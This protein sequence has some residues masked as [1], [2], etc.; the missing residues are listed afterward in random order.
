MLYIA[1]GLLGHPAKPSAREEI[2]SSELQLQAMSQ[3]IVSHALS[4]EATT[5]GTSHAGPS[6]S[7]SAH[8]ATA[9][10]SELSQ[11]L[12]T[13]TKDV[14]AVAQAIRESLALLAELVFGA[15]EEAGKGRDAGAVDEQWRLVTTALAE[16]ADDDGATHE[17][18]H[19]GHDCRDP[20]VTAVPADIK[21]LLSRLDSRLGTLSDQMMGKNHAGQASYPQDIVDIKDSIHR[22]EDSLASRPADRAQEARELATKDPMMA[23]HEIAGRLATAQGVKD[24]H[25]QSVVDRELF[26]SKLHDLHPE[27]AGEDHMAAIREIAGQLAT[28]QGVKELHGQSVADRE[29]LVSKVRDLQAEQAE[30]RSARLLSASLGRIGVARLEDLSSHT[31]ANAALLKSES[32][33]RARDFDRLE[34]LVGRNRIGQLEAQH[35]LEERGRADQGA[36]QECV[37]MLRGLTAAPEPPPVVAPSHA[38]DGAAPPAI[39]QRSSELA[40]DRTEQRELI[41]QSAD[42]SG[43]LDRIS[44]MIGRNRVG[45]LEAQHALEERRLADQGALQECLELLRELVSVQARDAVPGVSADCGIAASDRRE[46]AEERAAQLEAIARTVD[47]SISAAVHASGFTAERVAGDSRAIDQLHAELCAERATVDAREEIINSMKASALSSDAQLRA[48]DGIAEDLSQLGERLLGGQARILRLIGEQ[49][50]EVLE[51]VQEVPSTLHLQS[52]RAEALETRG[53]RD[54]ELAGL[55]DSL[56][57]LQ[58]QMHVQ[59]ALQRI[60][61]QLARLQLS[62]S[63]M[64][65]APMERPHDTRDAG[66]EAQRLQ[67]CMEGLQG[68]MLQSLASA[69]TTQAQQLQALESAQTSQLQAV[70]AEM[71]AHESRSFASAVE[72]GEELAQSRAQAQVEAQRCEIAE[73]RLQNVEMQSQRAGNGESATLWLPADRDNGTPRSIERHDPTIAFRR[74]LERLG[75]E[76]ARKDDVIAELHEELQV[77]RSRR[78]RISPRDPHGEMFESRMPS[79]PPSSANLRPGGPPVPPLALHGSSFSGG[80]KKRM[81][82][83]G[84]PSP[85]VSFL[86]PLNAKLLQRASL[87]GRTAPVSML[88]L[89]PADTPRVD[90]RLQSQPL[91]GDF[92]DMESTSDTTRSAGYTGSFG[93]AGVADGVSVAGSVTDDCT[94]GVGV[95]GASRSGIS[96]SGDS[97]VANGSGGASSTSIQIARASGSNFSK[98]KSAPVRRSVDAYAEADDRPE[99]ARGLSQTHLRKNS[100]LPEAAHAVFPDLGPGTAK[101]M[102]PQSIED[103]L[104]QS[105]KFRELSREQ[106]SL[107]VMSFSVRTFRKGD[108]VAQQGAA[109]EEFFIIGSGQ[110]DSSVGPEKRGSLVTGEQIGGQ[111][112]KLGEPWEATFKV[113]SSTA[114][115]WSIDKATYMSVVNGLFGDT[116]LAGGLAQD[117]KDIFA[118]SFKMEVRNRGEEIITQGAPGTHFYSIVSGFLTMRRQGAPARMLEKGVCFGE[119]AMGSGSG[120]TETVLVHSDQAKLWSIERAGFLVVLRGLLE[121]SIFADLPRE[122]LD[123]VMS[124]F[125]IIHRRS[126][127]T[128][129]SQNDVGSTFYVVVSGQ[130]RVQKSGRAVKTLEVG[131]WFGERALLEDAPRAASV[132]VRSELAMLWCVGKETFAEAL[133]PAVRAKLEARITAERAADAT[134]PHRR[135]FST[136]SSTNW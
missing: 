77:E 19:I 100:D 11:T 6:E 113:S 55:K 120:H 28:A 133:T 111:V 27:Q 123:L 110:I 3:Q 96:V 44:K 108:V 93:S 134:P 122:L 85:K 43:D 114:Q 75:H 72:A 106:L 52:W 47:R 94:A 95:A 89:S 45:Q 15:L 56:S 79:V 112:L 34:H 17:P 66:A 107:L 82:L 65:S 131:D 50:V 30:T 69:N 13:V 80:L 74:E 46:L 39:D 29:L 22:L 64:A 9:Y 132:I 86:D 41:A 83:P 104:H 102:L 38:A 40:E 126:G 105:P 63:T 5:A 81:S 99:W 125:E 62:A 127:D 136:R 49:R 58:E 37:A 2:G 124:N 24:L 73:L 1:G 119:N 116:L 135:H 130:L 109:A 25:D 18:Q 57:T 88:S 21:Q 78:I 53:V 103:F 26:A 4:N 35:A 12:L 32:D 121:S 67:Q 42:Y 101:P 92:M 8:E 33:N 70:V 68:E 118:S 54:E 23:I 31:A 61:E 36:L 91:T 115:L 98:T 87:P 60:E 51:A 128:I 10:L 97:G 59:P 7:T 71:M 117:K 76:A 14:P 48:T 90:P 84:G 16:L 129:F 20:C